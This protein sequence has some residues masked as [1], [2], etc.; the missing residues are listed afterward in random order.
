MC[1]LTEWT[2][3]VSQGFVAGKR[4]AYNA[5]R[6]AAPTL[7]SDLRR[8]VVW[9]PAEGVGA[10]PVED[11]LLAHAKVCQLAVAVCV[12]QDVVELQV[13]A[14]RKQSQTRLTSSSWLQPLDEIELSKF[15]TKTF[16]SRLFIFHSPPW[17]V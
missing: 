9:R 16:F 13:P 15:N 1:A 7:F 2:R 11:A 17:N 3:F 14:G 8:D 6:G 12:Q 10:D 4:L 5:A